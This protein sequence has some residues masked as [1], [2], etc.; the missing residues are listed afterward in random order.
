MVICF[1]EF[2]HI[3]R[4]YKLSKCLRFSLSLFLFFMV[5]FLINELMAEIYTRRFHC[6][7]CSSQGDRSCVFKKNN[8]K[9]RIF[10][11][12][13]TSRSDVVLY[14]KACHC[15]FC[16]LCVCVLVCAIYF[17]SEYQTGITLEASSFF[18]PRS[19]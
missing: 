16:P 14:Y 17:L 10:R 18:S 7:K 9:P 15:L 8:S 1:S 12:L 3:S 5:F 13:N 4:E 2:S 11:N 19:Q 6:V